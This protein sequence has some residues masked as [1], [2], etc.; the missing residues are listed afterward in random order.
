MK[1]LLKQKPFYQVYKQGQVFGTTFKNSNYKVLREREV[2]KR[3][4][5]AAQSVIDKKL[6][7]PFDVDP[8]SLLG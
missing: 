4:I 6:E 5:M 2:H 3:V 8:S 7:L 1:G